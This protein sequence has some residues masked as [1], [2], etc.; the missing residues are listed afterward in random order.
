[1]KHDTLARLASPILS[2]YT[3][4][5]TEGDKGSPSRVLP[6]KVEILPMAMSVPKMTYEY[7]TLSGEDRCTTTPT[8]HYGILP[9]HQNISIAIWTASSSSN[10]VDWFSV[11]LLPATA[12]VLAFTTASPIYVLYPPVNK[13]DCYKGVS[14]PNPSSFI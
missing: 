14:R 10:A 6:T 13:L 9:R 2:L 7:S 4:I 12:L 11:F 3:I 8:A 1:M 5:C